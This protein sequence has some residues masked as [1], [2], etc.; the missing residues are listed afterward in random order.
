MY[1]FVPVPKFFHQMASTLPGQ[2][3]PRD[4]RLHIDATRGCMSKQAHVKPSPRFGSCFVPKKPG[5]NNRKRKQD[6]KEEEAKHTAEV[7]TTQ[8]QDRPIPFGGMVMG[9]SLRV[10][11]GHDRYFFDSQ[12]LDI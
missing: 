3:D 5:A 12:I 8:A 2:I 9:E 11:D 6:E 4:T 10:Q 1:G 7:G